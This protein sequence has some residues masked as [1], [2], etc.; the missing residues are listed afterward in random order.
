MEV[1][2]HAEAQAEA[3]KE[4]E[5]EKEK[6][7]GNEDDAEDRKPGPKKRIS[8]TR[9]RLGDRDFAIVQLADRENISLEE[10]RGRLFG[11]S[12]PEA[13]AAQSAEAA[14]NSAEAREGTSPAPTR[15]SPEAIQARIDGLLEQRK[16]ANKALDVEK[17]T[18]LTDQIADLKLLQRDAWQDLQSEAQSRAASHRDAV[19]ASANQAVGL[20]PDAGVEGKELFEAI[21]AERIERERTDPEFFRNPRWP[22]TLAVEVATD[23]GIAP[24]AKSS[25]SAST[26][27]NANANAAAATAAAAAAGRQAPALPPKKAARPAPPNPAPGTA[28]G[29]AQINQ[30]DALRTELKAAKTS[31]DATA[32]KAVMRKIDAFHARKR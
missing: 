32:I 16:A 13:A 8:V 22:I 19:I 25:G 18:E 14:A 15:E 23:L 12:T 3:E 4:E 10:A 11:N 24:Q 29:A 20:Y 31:K 30:E 17:A 21:D 1:S 9:G 27:A 26:T 6:A 7:Q 2:A 28:T 5:Q